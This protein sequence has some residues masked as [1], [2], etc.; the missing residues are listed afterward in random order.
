MIKTYG[1]ETIRYTLDDVCCVHG[2]KRYTVVLVCYP[3]HTKL[4]KL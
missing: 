4:P 1:K 3:N 2:T